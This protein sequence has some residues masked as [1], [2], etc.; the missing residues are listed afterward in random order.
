MAALVLL[1]GL[2]GTGQLLAEFAASLSPEIKVIVAS[3]P[4]ETPLCYAELEAVARSFLPLD[5]PYFL[6]GE[7]FSGPIALSIAASSPPGLR[8]LILCCS[9]ARNP[10][11]LLA[12]FRPIFGVVP[13]AALPTALL[14]F[15]TLGRF[16][17]PTLRKALAQSLRLAAPSVLRARA[18]A[19]LSVDVSDRVS[20]IK[21][22]ML[23]LRASEDRIVPK[24]SSELIASLA[25]NTKIVEFEAP[26]FLL[27]TLSAPVA[28]VVANFIGIC[29]AL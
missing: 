8:G 18:C 24:A 10:L 23:Y 9:F 19:A 13:V 7:S 29:Q 2:D 5:Q 22:P 12:P 16:S 28:A 6:L 27:Q 26:H 1:P 4:L 21:L 25:P 3:Y 14:S 11:P 20:G 17:S 15:F